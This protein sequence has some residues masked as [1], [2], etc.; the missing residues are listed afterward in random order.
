MRAKKN[1]SKRNPYNGTQRSVE[2]KKKLFKKAVGKIIR[3]EGFYGLGVNK[4]ANV[5]GVS[6]N[7]IYRYFG[8]YR[9][10]VEQY[11]TDVDFWLSVFP[12][13]EF[14]EGT[15]FEYASSVL[16]ELFD[17]LIANPEMQKLILWELHD[18]NYNTATI[19]RKR[20]EVAEPFFKEVD[21]TLYKKVDFR[22]LCAILVSSV[23][24]LSAYSAVQQ[25]TFCGINLRDEKERKRIF[26]T[27]KFILT[28]IEKNSSRII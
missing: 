27:I 23:Y 25:E 10:L 6:K 19:L 14:T 20:E 9:N 18:S 3:E 12:K 21:S 11:A 13:L 5:A 7:L 4:V 24:H 1:K 2:E 8:N 16:V 22:A 17:Y 28:S 15:E 26:D